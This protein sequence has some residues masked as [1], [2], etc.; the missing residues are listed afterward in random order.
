MK[1][2]NPSSDERPP[3]Q[4]AGQIIFTSFHLVRIG[5]YFKMLLTHIF[6]FTNLLFKNKNK[7]A[8]FFISVGLTDFESEL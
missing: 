7:K 3:G 2:E 4:E 8:D 6:H 1:F 5:K